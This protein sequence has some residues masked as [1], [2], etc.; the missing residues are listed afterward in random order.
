MSGTLVLDD[1]SH[2]TG[3]VTGFA[4]GDMINLVGIAP[5]NVHVTNSGHFCQVLRRSPLG[6]FGC[7]GQS[8]VAGAELAVR[9]ARLRCWDAG[10]GRDDPSWVPLATGWN[11][12]LRRDTQAA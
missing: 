3:T 4:A 5:A 10:P 2:F 8:P 1:A 6:L 12:S 9:S 7:R 11:N